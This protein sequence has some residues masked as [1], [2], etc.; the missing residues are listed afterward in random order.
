MAGM[1]SF[2]DFEKEYEELLVKMAVSS[3]AEQ[4]GQDYLEELQ[5]LN[6][7]Q[8]ALPKE[9]LQRLRRAK[10]RSS[11]QVRTRSVHRFPRRFAQIAA[12]FFMVM[13]VAFSSTMVTV[14]G[15]RKKVVGYIAEWSDGLSMFTTRVEGVTGSN[16]PIYGSYSK[17]EQSFLWL[18]SYIPEGYVEVDRNIS[19][20]GLQESI[21]FRKSETEVI[22]IELIH[23]QAYSY[24][25]TEDALVQAIEINGGN[26]YVIQKFGYTTVWWTDGEYQYWLSGTLSWEEAMK[27]AEDTGFNR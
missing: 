14:E 16:S 15:D 9:A 27:M 2:G 1:F 19:T 13:L 26:G 6:Q 18:P 11:F 12:V 20:P 22:D 7:G 8:G 5:R 25:D 3:Y 23:L 21:H 17:P 4:M 24:I 10:R